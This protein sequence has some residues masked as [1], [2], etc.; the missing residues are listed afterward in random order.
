[1][2]NKKTEVNEG[3]GEEA[4]R[5]LGASGKEETLPNAENQPTSK[6]ASSATALPA[7]HPP[8]P[9]DN[10][11][12]QNVL[13]MFIETQAPEIVRSH[14]ISKN[15]AKGLQRDNCIGLIAWV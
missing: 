10:H 14:S 8:K 7:A 4:T 15:S 11:L 5:Q 9:N 3:V 13:R 6:P 2:K 12:D 1:M